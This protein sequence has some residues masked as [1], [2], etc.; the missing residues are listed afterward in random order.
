MES[1]NIRP[2]MKKS[3]L[4]IDMPTVTNR[5]SDELKSKSHYFDNKK[6][7]ELLT[8]YVKGGCVDVVL[9]DEIM[10]HAMELLRQVIRVHNFHNIYPGHDPASFGDLFNTAWM[11][12]EKC[13]Y[14]FNYKPG[15]SKVFN[16]W[17]QIS[18]TVILAHIKRENRDKKNYGSYKS[19]VE[20]HQRPKSAVFE[21]F[22]CE[23]RSMSQYDN[24]GLK[25]I[26]ALEKLYKDDE[27]AHEGLIGKLTKI[28]GISRQKIVQFLKQIRLR[29]FEFTD[30][31]VNSERVGL[32]K[33]SRKDS[34]IDGDDEN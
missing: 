11:Q 6:V 17:S 23:A 10:A 27:R 4:S 14:K 26:D 7:E 8:R 12:I 19:H 13:L 2:K 24:N 5:S 25:I 16:L 3:K 28:T 18:K 29:S 15:H 21:R 33:G 1:P 32:A 9:R 30:A 20:T 34:D 31:P 22:F